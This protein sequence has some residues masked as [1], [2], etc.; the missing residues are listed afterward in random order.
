MPLHGDHPTIVRLVVGVRGTVKMH[1]E[2]ILRFGYGAI[3]PWVSRL[4]NG[5]LRAIAGPDMM[6]VHT[7]VHLRGEDMTTIGEFTVN[8]D[9]TIPFV[10]SYL[11]SHRP[12]HE[13]FDPA[14]A[15]WRTR[16]TFW[17]DWSAKCTGPP[18]RGRTPSCAR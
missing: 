11:P 4:E 15:L 16:E 18:A 9:E 6:V 2:L 13:P 7:P 17:H 8:R 3:V 1:A 5:G 10:L 12:L 14:T